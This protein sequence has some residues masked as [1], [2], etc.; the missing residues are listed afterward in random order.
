MT[1]FCTCMGKWF[2]NLSLYVTYQSSL[3][4]VLVKCKCIINNVSVKWRPRDVGNKACCVAKLERKWRDHCNLALMLVWQPSRLSY[5]GWCSISQWTCKWIMMHQKDCGRHL[6]Y[7]IIKEKEDP[8]LFSF[9][10]QSIVI[11]LSVKT[12]IFRSICLLK[13]LSL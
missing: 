5:L 7:D 11:L 1:G 10:E 9:S 3:K 2:Q 8:N 4:E 12:M 6:W 13:F